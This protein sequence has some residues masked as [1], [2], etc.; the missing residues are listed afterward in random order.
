MKT[1][2][3]RSRAA[4]TKR[5]VILSAVLSTFLQFDFHGTKLEQIVELAS[6]SKTNLLYYFPSKGALYIAMLRQILGV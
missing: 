5:K 2:G 1:T 3:K 4:N 6:V